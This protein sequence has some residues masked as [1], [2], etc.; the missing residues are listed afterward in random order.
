MG[1]SIKLEFKLT[2]FQSY[3]GRMII[4]GCVHR[5]SFKGYKFQGQQ[6]SSLYKQS[7]PALNRIPYQDLKNLTYNKILKVWTPTVMFYPNP[8]KNRKFC[9]FSL[10]VHLKDADGL[11]NSED[12]DQLPL[13]L[14]SSELRMAGKNIDC[15]DTLKRCSHEKQ[16]AALTLCRYISFTI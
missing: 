2:V 1:G 12:P 15:P 14:G 8:P 4:K 16:T 5:T 13:R 7:K 10:T 11:A 3:R 6:N 9:S